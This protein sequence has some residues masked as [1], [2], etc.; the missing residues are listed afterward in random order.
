MEILRK[1]SITNTILFNPC[2]KYNYTNAF[3]KN[4]VSCTEETCFFKGAIV[5]WM[6]WYIA[7]KV[8]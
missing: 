2:C 7:R 6:A 4:D 5:T 1:A 8:G 3:T